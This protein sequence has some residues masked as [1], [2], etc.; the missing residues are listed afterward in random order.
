[1]VFTAKG[2]AALLAFSLVASPA[3]AMLEERGPRSDGPEDSTLRNVLPGG[4]DPLGVVEPLSRRGVEFRL[5]Y[6]ADL[7]G[8]V[9]GGQRQGWIGQGLFEPSIEVNF[10]R[11]AGLTG[12]RG[13]ANAFFIHN[14]GRMR[15][16][17]VG[18]VNTVAAIEAMPRVRLSELWL[19][20]RFANGAVRLRAGQIA[21][22]VEFLY[23]DLSV[24]FL[25]SDFPTISALN[26][27]DGGPAFPLA[28]P[29]I[30]VQVEPNERFNFRAALFNGQ[31][32]PPGDGDAQV[33]NRYNTNFRVN[34][35]GLVF[36]EVRFQANQAKD[37]RGPARII[38]L[39]GWGH[40]GRFDNTRRA[41][42]GSALADP[43][44]SGV[45]LRRRGNGGLYA[46][47]DQQLWRPINGDPLSGISLFGRVSISPSDRS[48]I[49][50]YADGGMVFANVL[51]SRPNDRFGVSVIYARY[52]AGL[53]GYD[54]DLTQFTSGAPG[55]RSGETSLEMNYLAEIM[56]GFDI[57]PMVAHVWNPSEKPGRNAFVVGVR[58]RILY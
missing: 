17:Y 37:A 8:N 2:L 42:D 43:A 39:G 3:Q 26:L 12:L 7:L 11:L 28:A 51:P 47:L 56:P 30:F 57:Q 24:M 52:A 10:E 23:S 54:A 44:G 50:F 31:V 48:A 9:R 1:M 41:A 55:Q 38:R 21:A 49:S 45:P 53:R 36:A 35:P 29:G 4:S 27:P 18:G 25:H 22:D 46:V 13:Y 58:T 32:A 19:E 14:N 5:S 40:L 20:Q 15:R 16:D 33:R 34:D 6:I